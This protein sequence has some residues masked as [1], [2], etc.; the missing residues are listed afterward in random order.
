LASGLN[1]TL[2]IGVT[3]D[4]IK[5]VTAKAW[6]TASQNSTVKNLVWYEVHSEIAEAIRA[7]NRSRSG[8]GAGS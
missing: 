6:S 1:G 3:S 5:R 8:I 4:M 2:Y 7:K